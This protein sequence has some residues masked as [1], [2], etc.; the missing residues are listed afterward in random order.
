MIA[1]LGIAV[2]IVTFIACTKEKEQINIQSLNE[3]DGRKPIATFDNATGVIT[4]SFDLSE[5][6]Q[7]ISS[8]LALRSD[9]DRFII[10]SIIIE[11]SVPSDIR[12]LPEIR[13]T[14]LDTEEEVSY[15]MWY[16]RKF[17]N[18]EVNKDGT[19][20]YVDSEV[21]T[22]IY[23]FAYH[24]GDT[25]YKAN[26]NGNEITTTEI[27]ST[28]CKDMIRWFFVCLQKGCEVSCTK[29]GSFWHG[30][31]NPCPT[32]PGQCSQEIAPWVTP[33]ISFLGALIIA[34]L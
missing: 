4:Y 17:A 9:Q 11:D 15:T 12:V 5:V 23:E 1:I 3:V 2:F 7:K 16:M 20:Y 33:T 24:I 22:G 31:C 19:N 13:I 32:P 10:E 18:K 30:Y 25:Y 6:Q 29:G 28:L 26:V 21:R 34:L 14:V 8:D 27:D